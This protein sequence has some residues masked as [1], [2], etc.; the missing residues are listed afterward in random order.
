[1]SD[2]G[3]PM[4]VGGLARAR[5]ES[6]RAPRGRVAAFL[7]FVVACTQVAMALRAF[8]HNWLVHYRRHPAYQEENFE[9]WEAIGA[10]IT[11]TAWFHLAVA[12]AA[13]AIMLW[14]LRKKRVPLIALLVVVL[15]PLAAAAAV[16]LMHVP[17]DP[18]AAR[19]PRFLGSL[20]RFALVPA[21]LIV[22][23]A[24]LIVF[25]IQH[26]WRRRGPD[27]EAISKAF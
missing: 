15:L 12:V 9:V 10:E 23:G 5:I 21:S 13:L 7:L 26:R 22:D 27:L 8:V 14:I 18:D 3:A 2:G 20:R 4:A 11:G 1:M 6:T 19:D 24:A 17:V 16:Y 25:V